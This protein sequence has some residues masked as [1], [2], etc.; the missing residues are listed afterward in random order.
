MEHNKE[1]RKIKRMVWM[2]K[3]SEEQYE[4]LRQD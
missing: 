1:E 4:T 2:K 3:S